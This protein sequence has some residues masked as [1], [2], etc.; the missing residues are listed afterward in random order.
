[1]KKKRGG[2]G[3]Q[4]GD[5]FHA[6]MKKEGGPTPTDPTVTRRIRKKD[7]TPSW[8]SQDEGKSDDV[9]TNKGGG[10]LQRLLS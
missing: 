9:F 5:H 8:H 3:F 4:L 1:V 10:L 7:T 2:L 6:A